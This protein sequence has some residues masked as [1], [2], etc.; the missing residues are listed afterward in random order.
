[1]P[2]VKPGN[3]AVK[4]VRRTWNWI[5]LGASCEC[6][7]RRREME[8]GHDGRAERLAKVDDGHHYWIYHIPFSITRALSMCTQR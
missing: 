7:E 2:L 4:R 1:M 5:L 8:G 3:G 6:L